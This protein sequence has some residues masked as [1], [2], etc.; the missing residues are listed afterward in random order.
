ME[1]EF[2]KAKEVKETFIIFAPIARNLET[3]KTAAMLFIG[4]HNDL[5]TLLTPTMA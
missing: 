3:H 1:I 4:I 2:I 5:Q